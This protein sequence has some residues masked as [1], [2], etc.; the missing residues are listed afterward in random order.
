MTVY[1]ACL[2]HLCYTNGPGPVDYDDLE[3][4]ISSLIEEIKSFARHNKITRKFRDLSRS[5]L[6]INP[7]YVL[8]HLDAHPELSHF[9]PH[10]E[11]LRIYTA[12]R[13]AKYKFAVT[14]CAVPGKPKISYFKSIKSACNHVVELYGLKS[15]ARSGKKSIKALI[16]TI[17]RTKC[18]FF[19]AACY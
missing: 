15:Q 10:G 7:A 11:L 1:D 16:L 5:D 8:E 19:I 2:N 3:Q 12:A 9:K 6:V 17:I 14:T 4:R 18:E 13:P